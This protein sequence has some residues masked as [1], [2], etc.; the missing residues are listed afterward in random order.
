MITTF[1]LRYRSVLRALKSACT[2]VLV[3][4]LLSCGGDGGTS[5]ES[6][7]ALA[8]LV[9][10]SN[11]A[12]TPAAIAAAKTS[13]QLDKFWTKYGA[14]STF[15]K[16]WVELLTKL[17]EAE[18]KV[19]LEDFKGARV[20][21]DELM[22]K[23]PLMNNNSIGGNAWWDN[24]KKMNDKVGDSRPHLGEPSLYSHL[25]ILDDITKVGV[26]KTLVGKT[27]LRMAVVIPACSD[28]V[29]ER[30][31][32]LINERLS[33]EI[34]ANDYE[35]VRQSMRLFQS[36][37][38]A[39]SG[40]ELRLELKFY[41]IE[42]CL[43]IKPET[44]Y[45]LDSIPVPLDQLPEGEAKKADMFW[46]IYPNDSSKGADISIMGGMSSYG[47]SKPLFI[48]PD[49]MITKK[50]D[51]QGTGSR[52]DVERRTYIPQWAQHEFFHHLFSAWPEFNLETNTKGH[53]WND[54]NFWPL[55]FTGQIEADY[56]SE[57]LNKRLYGAKSG[58]ISEKLKR[59]N[60]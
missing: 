4:S 28:I 59:A 9:P 35:V 38:L 53:D 22:K 13:A 51:T 45:L 36:Y 39:M 1:D 15:D 27:T 50:R 44:R 37:L 29:P 56:Y 60:K 41:K 16:D 20:I 24:Y 21:V 23:F 17:L 26:S 32:T 30:G 42:K 33:P 57:A 7:A 54:K 58:S 10:V 11:P 31:P 19:V 3:T 34:E 46:M 40:G 25:R 2:A 14:K 6:D 52:T 43:Q 49:S 12:A 8:P 18:D 47:N 55:D 5:A 48:S